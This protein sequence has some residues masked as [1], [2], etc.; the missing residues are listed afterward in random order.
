[1]P[2]IVE[3][4]TIQKRARP[5]HFSSGLPGNSRTLDVHTEIGLIDRLFVSRSYLNLTGWSR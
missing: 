3:F 1:M 5:I 2:A 4:R